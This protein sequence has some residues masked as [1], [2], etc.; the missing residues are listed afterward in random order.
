[1][2]MPNIRFKIYDPFYKTKTRS[3][4]YICMADFYVGFFMNIV[5]AHSNT[6]GDPPLRLYWFPQTSL[7]SSVLATA[8]EEDE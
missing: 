2:R 7:H 3:R 4:V 1:M 6:L 5:V 8:A